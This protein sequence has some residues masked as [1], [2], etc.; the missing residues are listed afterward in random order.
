MPAENVALRMSGGRPKTKKMKKPTTHK[1]CGL[2][3]AFVLAMTVG[4]DSLFAQENIVALG[5]V[6]AAG[7]VLSS[8]NT[9]GGIVTASR[10]GIG[11][12]S[13]TVTS[14]GAFTGAGEFDFAVQAAIASSASGD[15]TIKA[16]LTTITND[17]VTFTVHVDDVENSLDPDSGVP[18]DAPFFF[19]LYRVPGAFPANTSARYLLGT[20]IVQS[21]GGLVNGAAVGGVTISTSLNALGDYSIILSE[22]DGFLGD[23]VNDYVLE[24][25]IR[26]TGTGA[27]VVR[28]E[29]VDVSSNHQLVINVH[30]DDVQA[31]VAGNDPM[32]ENSDFYFTVYR[33]PGV[34]Q[35]LAGNRLVTA[36]AAVGSGGT[37]LTPANSMDGGT[38]SSTRNDMGDYRVTIFSPGAFTGRAANEFVAQATLRQ[39]WSD[40]EGIRADAVIADANTL[41]ID[42]R[43]NDLEVA[44]EPEGVPSDAAF[45]L[46]ILDIAEVAAEVTAAAFVQPDLRIGHRRNIQRM[47]GNDIYNRNAARQRIGLALTGLRWS[48]YYFVLENDGNVEDRIRL[49]ET[50]RKGKVQT[51]YFRLTGGRQNITRQVTRSGSV[52]NPMDP[53]AFIRYEARVKYET[54]QSRPRQNVRLVARSMTDTSK[55]DVV[56]TIVRP[57]RR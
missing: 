32:P 15:E 8:D 38:L 10:P 14:A 34:A 35:P 5:R 26:G 4:S 47:K 37:L 43:V 2:L 31:I 9:A 49:N 30:T 11:S 48:R 29:V 27:E 1:L 44:G 36:V 3:A 41:H 7:A 52:E 13:V 42:V 56:R 17:S 50:G 55:L 57:K 6:S 23:A 28:G 46:V 33:I 53:G 21:T 20:G 39:S 22:P 18:A 12:Y 24:L 51:R 40:D 19:T 54:R 25:T 45:Y 16:H